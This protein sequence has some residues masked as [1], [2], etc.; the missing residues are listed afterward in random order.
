VLSGACVVLDPP[1]TG[2][3]PVVAAALAAARP[4][5][6]VYVSCD[7]ATLARDLQTLTAAGLRVDT[8]TVF[9]LFPVTAHVE[10]VVTLS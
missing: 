6:V 10:T 7:P 2:L 3:S 5:R 1:R 8:M 4:R 9:D